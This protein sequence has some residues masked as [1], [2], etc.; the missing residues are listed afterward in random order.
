[1]WYYLDKLLNLLDI[2]MLKRIRY[3]LWALPRRNRKVVVDTCILL[4]RDDRERLKYL[5]QVLI[6][7]AV[8][9]QI[10]RMAAAFEV[11]DA[12]TAK[13]LQ[14]IVKVE[15]LVLGKVA[16]RKWQIVG[17][18]GTGLLQAIENKKLSELDDNL[19]S[20]IKSIFSK[21]KDVWN[22][23]RGDLGLSPLV[24]NPDNLALRDLLGSTDLRI[25]TACL[26]LQR[27]DGAGPFWLATRDKT[28]LAL[29]KE[30]EIRTVQRIKEL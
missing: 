30:L 18:S 1:L 17:S 25:L 26:N 28:V 27:Q 14:D 21:R 9:E 5:R 24:F 4:N 16:D 3:F 11:D 13:K 6:P 29:A 8:Q 12:N 22:Q 23:K 7:R 19:V 15:E 2:K 10:S 20:H